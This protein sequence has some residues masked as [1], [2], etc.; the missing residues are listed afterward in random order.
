MYLDPMCVLGVSQ[1]VK[2]PQFIKIIDKAKLIL[3]WTAVRSVKTIHGLTKELE[4][5]LKSI[6]DQKL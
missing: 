4:Q 1:T 5:K 6:L 2:T 3:N